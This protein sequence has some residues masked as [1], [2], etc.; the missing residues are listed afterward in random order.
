MTGILRRAIDKLSG[1]WNGG[2][3]RVL[4][5]HTR[6]LESGFTP[7]GSDFGVEIL[8]DE[9][10]PMDFVIEQLVTHAGLAKKDAV[11]T[12]LGIHVQ[13]GVLL[14][15]PSEADAVRVASDISQRA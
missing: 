10:T 11:Q 8:N 7:P 6:L 4:A 15:L 12:M 9:A 1:F 14:P 2:E 13:G 5:P 3:Q